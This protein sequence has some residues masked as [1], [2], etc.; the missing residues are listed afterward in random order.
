MVTFISNRRLAPFR[1]VYN[2]EFQYFLCFQKSEYLLGY[3]DFVDIFLGHHKTGL[4]GGGSF[5]YI[6]WYFLK[7][8]VQNGNIFGVLLKLKI[9]IILLSK[10]LFNSRTLV[11]S[12]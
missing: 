11:K 10:F 9:F 12:V 8:K 4:F 6:L 2:F 7:V 1:G 3:E 5:L